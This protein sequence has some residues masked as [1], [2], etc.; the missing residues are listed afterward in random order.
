[1]PI[2]TY[3]CNDCD[4]QFEKRQRMADDPLTECV[5][6]EAGHVR[7]V[8]NSVGIVFKG[9]GFYVTDNRNGN[10]KGKPA[11][12]GSGATADAGSTEKT[13][14]TAVKSESKKE[15]SKSKTA[16]EPAKAAG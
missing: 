4:Y 2:Y 5:H 7:R 3:R 10:G 12:N 8:V 16:K 15:E 13:E 14:K 1:M 9:S 11:A 6:C